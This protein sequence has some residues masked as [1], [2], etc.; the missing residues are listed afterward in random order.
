MI[1]AKRK[2]KKSKSRKGSSR[3]LKLPSWR[4]VR[5]G[6]LQ[7]PK[8]RL[9][10]CLGRLYLSRAVPRSVKLKI[11]SVAKTGARK[12]RTKVRSKT[13]RKSKSRKMRTPAQKRATRKLVA[14]N[15]RRR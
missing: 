9:V 14:F 8:I 6:L 4:E 15:K 2:G 13:K 5:A 7:A 12:V 1:M 11:I 10:A 3:K